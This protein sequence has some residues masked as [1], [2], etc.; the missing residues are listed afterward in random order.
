MT[1]I[2]RNDQPEQKWRRKFA[3]GLNRLR[4]TYDEYAGKVR[5]WLEEFEENPETVMNMIEAEEASFPLRARRVGEELEAVR[6]GFVES[7]RKAGTIR[8]VAEKLGLGQEIVAATAAVRDVTHLRGQLHQRLVRFREEI[9]GQ[10]KRNEKIR[11]LKNRF[12][13]RNRKGRRVD[14]HV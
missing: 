9:A 11:K 1:E 6:K 2:S 13:Q 7:S 10:R 4:A 14:G 5:G 8:D 12:S 3:E